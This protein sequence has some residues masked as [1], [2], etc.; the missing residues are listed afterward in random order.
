MLLGRSELE[1]KEETVPEGQSLIYT[2]E[3]TELGFP[4]HGLWF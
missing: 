3:N 1:F 4:M 2:E